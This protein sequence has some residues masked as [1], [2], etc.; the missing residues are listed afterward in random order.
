MKKNVTRPYRGLHTD[1]SAQDQP[2]DTYRF[3]LNAINETEI[4]DLFYNSNEE[5]NE[6]CAELPNGYIPL[7]KVYIGNGETL[8]FS[9]SSD[10][11]SS[12][13][14]IRD[15]ECN[16]TTHVNTDLGFKVNHQ[17]DSTY[18]LRRGCER[19]IYWVD[20]NNNKPRYYNIDK[21]EN[22]KTDGNWN[23]NKF[24]LN[25]SY[26]S[27]PIFDEVE[28]LNSGGQLEPGSYNIAIQYLDEN[29]NPTEW[30]TSSEI[31][32]VYNDDTNEDFLDISGSI[33]QEDDYR[34][35][36]TTDKAIK[37]VFTD[38][39]KTFLFY[40]LAFIEATNGSGLVSNI[41][42]TENIPTSK[43]FYIYTGANFKTKGSSEEILAVNNIID[44]ADSIEQLENRLLLANVQGKQV[45]FCKLQQ[46]ASKIKADVITKKIITNIISEGNTK[47]ATSQFEGIGYM[48]GEIYSFGIVY[49]FKDGFLSPVY[50]IPGKSPKIDNDTVFNAGLN[51]YPMS[52]DN[53]SL[54]NIYTDNSACQNE[55]YWGV[56]SEGDPLTNQL[57]RHHRFPLRSKL[58]LP[59]VSVESTN[60][61][62][63]NFFQVKLTGTGTINTPCTQEQVD[64]G[65]CPSLQEA[66]SF[67]VQVEFTVD[68]VTDY[69]TIE[70]KPIDYFN[71]T[72]SYV[73]E[74]TELSNFYA[75]ENIVITKIEES[76]DDGSVLDVTDGSVSPHG[77]SYT[78]EKASSL[79]QSEGKVYSTEVFGIKF[80]GVELPPLSV[81]NG[82]EVVGYYIV[83]NERTEI[84]K[85]ILDS[86]V[87]T[88][89]IINNKY[90]SH[91]LLG[92]EFNDDS[93]ISKNIFGLI[94]PEH[95]FYDKKYS[96]Y[97][98][99]IQEGS[100]NITDRKKSVC[101]YLDVQD[102]TTYDPDNHKSEDNDGWSLK[103][104][105]RDNITNFEKKYDSFSIPETDIEDTFYLN[106]LQ[107]R[108]EDDK[109]IYNVTGDNRIGIV[110]LKNDLTNSIRNTFPYVYLKRNI[111]DSY[112][113]F[114]TLPYIKASVNPE[115]N[116]VTSVFNG[117]SYVSPMRYVNTVF[118]D[119]RIAKRAVKRSIWQIIAGVALVVV[120]AFLSVISLGL[121]A[122]PSTILIATGVS[123]VG[124]GVLFAAS[125]IKKE[126][127]AKAYYEEYEKGLR[128]T[129]LDNW[130]NDEYKYAR[131]GKH[132]TPQDD[133]I[134]WISDCV[135]DLWFESQVNTSLRYK[136]SSD[137]PTFLD[138]PGKIESGRSEPEQTGKDNVK[139]SSSKDV[140]YV[141][142]VSL[143]PFTKLDRH[144]M[145]KLSAFNAERK[146][147]RSYTGHCLGE[148]YKINP[149]YNR[150]N[151]QK[152]FF[153]LA[154]EYDCCS[155]CQEDFPHRVHYSE[156]SFQ[157]ELTDNFRVFLPNNYRDI[158][159]ETGKI[160]DLFR[161]KNNLYIHTEETLWHLPQNYQ[162]RIT[163]DIVSFIGS[164]EYFN[165]P[166]RKILDENQSS[167]GSKH[168]WATLKTKHGVFFVSEK[169]RKI[170][171]FNGNDLKPI[172]DIGN[173]SWFK[174]NQGIQL[175]QDYYIANG[176]YYP[177]DNNPSNS[178]GVGFISTYDT[179]KERVIFT[180]K[181][182]I[183][184]PKITN[185]TD[186]EIC[187]K[188]N[189]VI[190]FENY[191]QTITDYINNGWVYRG[192]ENCKMK[193]EKTVLQSVIEERESTVRV[194]NNAD[195][196]VQLDMSASFNATTRSQI[197]A[198][199]IS[200]KNNFASTNSD[201][202]GNLYFSRHSSGRSELYLQ[203]LE[204]IQ[205]G[206]RIFDTSD[207]P[208]SASVISDNI[209][210]VS[211]VNE[212]DS[213]HITPMDNPIPPP[214]TSAFDRD[215]NDF[216]NRYNNIVSK[217]GSFRGL[218]YPIV[219]P[220]SI[221][222]GNQTNAFLQ[223]AMAAVKG[224]PYTESELNSITPNPFSYNWS[225][226]TTSLQGDNPY[227]DVGL[228]QYGWQGRWDRGWGG[229][230]DIIT[231]A[232]FQEDMND[233][234]EGSQNK[235]VVKTEIKVPVVQVEYVEGSA[236]TEFTKA[237]NSWTMSYSLKG[238]HWVSWHSYMP[239]FYYYIPE[240]F[241]SWQHGN[242]NFWKH[243]KIGHY[244]TYYNNRHP[245][246]VEY[247]SLSEPIKTKIWDD[248]M[249]HTEAKKYVPEMK[250]YVDERNK[251]F[252]KAIMY[253]TRQCTGELNL[254]VKNTNSDSDNYMLQQVVNLI[255]GTI[256][257]DRNERN[258]TL[259]DI[260]DIRIDYDQPMFNSNIAS[261][262]SNYYIDKVLNNSSLNTNKDW[263]QL[264]SLRDKYLIIR[265]IFDNFSDIKLLM[266]Y[267]IES[268]NEVEE[269]FK[270]R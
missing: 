221:S 37:V 39:D 152:L 3:A 86:A 173:S 178:V 35:F 127:W 236:V 227:P 59:L 116:D 192:V 242:N 34:D 105:T 99:I 87:L 64:S 195:I 208:V 202:E 75:S 157:E 113:T 54:N 91:G 136:M 55:Q 31:I 2:K 151:I 118:W 265:L 28:V 170:F 248:I 212:T 172:S 181:D 253:N 20:G 123:I 41:K 243:N 204:W 225:F 30:I 81:T 78:A 84:E 233:F 74:L 14:G 231:P 228:D 175:L 33:N 103:T 159:G 13:L 131:Y 65:D 252:N 90:V 1:N 214:S 45:N 182:S 117:D 6:E 201:W 88:P 62:E 68:G 213:Y 267:S 134:Q 247:V 93:K 250:Q 44:S 8:I 258:W 174:E 108:E 53:Q 83:R 51:T 205:D 77:M 48:P 17:I 9:V 206:I 7:G 18:R 110:Q 100:F 109:T 42:Y 22:F 135:T 177:Y 26:S 148:W 79:F 161:I 56:D 58:N 27:I 140:Y 15:S 80:S 198:A 203:V 146:D 268:E 254:K 226:L 189:Q 255:P 143:Y 98:E 36:P 19:T 234:L 259:N 82:E 24:E 129:A 76:Q 111:A 23:A 120:G 121:S 241:Y 141:K 130:V 264:E 191:Q 46:Y 25:R 215:Y 263:T 207:N 256:I 166:P 66:P 95:K 147:N 69:L 16:Y 97:T 176:G 137:T 216:I 260:R 219:Y 224:V 144:V 217:G 139:L 10:E 96:E 188:N 142:D 199:V 187:V 209:I 257:I 47:S 11:S 72:N 160:T 92:A 94:H 52:N 249:L 153:H 132:D 122:V 167:G 197:Q 193:F 270:T 5:S 235:G 106:A 89:S 49:I 246:I 125:G 32:K 57:V 251:T 238:N 61:S 63:T 244:Q 180:K 223:H 145:N 29:L 196:I 156:Q 124:G 171:Q 169:E 158:E 239:N 194:A 240:K 163:N 222:W 269:N 185:N 102:G 112:S 149:D 107:S 229:S 115:Y 220:R 85:T 40:R 133:E 114:R 128:E 186:F 245:Y 261:V 50:H 104:I 183:L 154:L 155:D 232:Q 73:L 150:L 138:A 165:I 162:E 179:K 119:N 4:G 230:G 60:N 12:E 211:F 237:N 164:G 101:R 38:L 218:I 21:P 126:A 168:K 262:Q 67:Q 43:N 184:S 200:W 266:N 210:V 70:I 190:I 71:S